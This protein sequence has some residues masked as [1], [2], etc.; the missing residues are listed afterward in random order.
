VVV[1]QVADRHG[2]NVG[3]APAPG[4]GLLVTLTLPGARAIARVPVP[5]GR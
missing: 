5:A 4:G 3:A 1:R 2:G